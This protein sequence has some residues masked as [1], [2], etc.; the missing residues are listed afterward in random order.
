MEISI[1]DVSEL[2]LENY[3]LRRDLRR[4]HEA[5]QQLMLLLKQ[6]DAAAAGPEPVPAERTDDQPD[7]H[8]GH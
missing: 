8:E 5:N 7:H 3:T 6:N 1:A 2:A 4:A